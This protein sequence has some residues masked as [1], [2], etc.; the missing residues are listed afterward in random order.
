MI[1]SYTHTLQE[2]TRQVNDTRVDC[3]DIFSF[4]ELFIL[5]DS[6]ALHSSSIGLNNKVGSGV[7]NFSDTSPSFVLNLCLKYF[8]SKSKPLSDLRLTI[9]LRK[10]QYSAHP[11]FFFSA[12][13]L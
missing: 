1:L 13:S 10:D 6:N 4:W 8:S 3:L 11:T 7:Y 12:K 9:S 5:M 2:F